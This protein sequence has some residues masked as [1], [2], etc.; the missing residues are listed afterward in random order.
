MSVRRPELR[1]IPKKIAY[2][3][4]NVEVW[5]NESPGVPF[6]HVLFSPNLNK[7]IAFVVSGLQSRGRWSS[8][9]NLLKKEFIMHPRRFAFVAGIVM[10]VAGLLA[11]I[12]PGPVAGLPVLRLEQSYGFFLNLFP[13]N[14]VSKIAAIL[15]GGAG[16]AAANMKNTSLPNSI[17]WSRVVFYAMGALAILGLFPETNTLGGYWPLFGA[18]FWANAI[19]SLLGA[20]FGYYM[21]SKVHK[22]TKAELEYRTPMSSARY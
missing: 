11:L 5:D 8:N 12:V 10:L 7:F 20:W 15:L 4:W 16:I 3:V 13:M 18:S 9:G 1:R 2:R 6:L 22:P 17:L 19:F 21:S 14:I